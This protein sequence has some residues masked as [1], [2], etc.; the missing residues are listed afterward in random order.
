MTRAYMMNLKS[1]PTKIYLLLPYEILQLK[2]EMAGHRI[3]A[4][5]VS[6]RRLLCAVQPGVAG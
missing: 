2:L 4:Q 3:E 5:S 6:Y 1:K